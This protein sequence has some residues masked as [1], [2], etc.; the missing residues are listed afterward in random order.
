MA[1]K[2]EE[3]SAGA[4]PAA[5]R[6]YSAVVGQVIGKLLQIASKDKAVA[7]AVSDINKLIGAHAFVQDPKQFTAQYVS[8]YM[9]SGAF[10][11]FA[12]QL[13]AAEAEFF[14]TY[15]DIDSFRRLNPVKGMSLDDLQSTT[16]RPRATCERPM[17]ARRSLRFS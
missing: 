8:N 1:Q 9:I 17:R 14:S 11:K 10:G 15:P 5:Q 4:A 6:T 12:R 13:A 16:T 7:D 3:K 2:P